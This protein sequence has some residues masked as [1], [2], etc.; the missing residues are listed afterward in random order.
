MVLG[1]VKKGYDIRLGG[2]EGET[3]DVLGVDAGLT[4]AAGG[5]AAGDR[6]GD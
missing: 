4:A 6:N 3:F 2:L 5:L 1:G